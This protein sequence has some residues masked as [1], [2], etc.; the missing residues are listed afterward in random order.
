ML[1][2]LAPLVLANVVPWNLA[3]DYKT[4]TLARYR[5]TPRHHVCVTRSLCTSSALG[6][7]LFHKV[8]VHSASVCL[9][10]KIS[11]RNTASKPALLTINSPV[12]HECTVLH[13]LHDGCVVTRRVRCPLAA[14]P[15]RVE[16]LALQRAHDRP[17]AAGIKA[18]EATKQRLTAR[19]AV[20]GAVSSEPSAWERW[21]GGIGRCTCQAVAP[22]GV[23]LRHRPSADR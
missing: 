10:R 23:A 11:C 9:E 1:C 7:S 22:S 19:G 2:G 14:E 13:E 5:H 16:E 6:V 21:G 15:Q 3:D 18:H 20:A 12:L 17:S 8:C 4:T